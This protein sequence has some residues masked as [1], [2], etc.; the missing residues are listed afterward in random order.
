M[1]NLTY[2]LTH[3]QKCDA[4]IEQTKRIMQSKKLSETE[5]QN[6]SIIISKFEKFKK[7]GVYGN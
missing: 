7:E 3:E 5:L 6:F 4:I 1:L 2:P